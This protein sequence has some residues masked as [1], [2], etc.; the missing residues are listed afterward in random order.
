MRT[1]LP[2]EQLVLACNLV[3]VEIFAA[4]QAYVSCSIFQST[5]KYQATIE[6][7][8]LYR[9]IIDFQ[10]LVQTGTSCC[11]LRVLILT[12]IPSFRQSHL[13]LWGESRRDPNLLRYLRF[14]R[15]FRLEK[16]QSHLPSQNPSLPEPSRQFLGGTRINI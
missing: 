11:L 7:S 6:Y 5:V 9:E 4:H 1:Y 15:L 3:K 2:S 16:D 14:Y 12:S 10:G 13:R 8:S